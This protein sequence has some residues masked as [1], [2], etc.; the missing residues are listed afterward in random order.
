MRGRLKGFSGGR[1][2]VEVGGQKKIIIER[3]KH[4]EW[5]GEK[6]SL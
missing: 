3:G 2:L 5:G 4:T 6:G 1:G